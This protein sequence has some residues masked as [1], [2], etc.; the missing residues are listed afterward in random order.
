[1]DVVGGWLVA[2]ERQARSPNRK[3][4]SVVWRGEMECGMN[5]HSGLKST[6]LRGRRVMS[7]ISWSCFGRPSGGIDVMWI[8]VVVVVVYRG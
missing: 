6:S 3:A 7:N 2:V 5:L 8:W 1:M 4:R